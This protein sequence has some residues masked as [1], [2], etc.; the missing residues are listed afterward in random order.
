[1]AEAE[2]AEL[3]SPPSSGRVFEHRQMPGIADAVSDG[4]VRL[5]AIGRWLADVAY[6]DLLDAG[7]REEGLWVVRRSRI[8]VERFPPF[9]EEVALR[10]FC[11]GIGRFSAERRT[12]ITGATAAV[13]AVGL[14]VWLDRETLRPQRFAPEFLDV[15]RES[16]AGREANVRLKHPDRPQHGAGES[17]RFRASD[18]DVAGHVNNASY[19]AVLEEELAGSEPQSIDVEIEYREP[20]QAGTACVVRSGPRRWIVGEGATTYASLLV[21]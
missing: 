4:R 1:L 19:L 17:W 15:Y 16:A 10:T 8:R 14:W 21:A 2:L 20:A 12:T 7:L 18:L 13:E 6:L 3:V 5:D 11:S 9:G